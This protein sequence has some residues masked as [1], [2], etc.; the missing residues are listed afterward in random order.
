MTKLALQIALCAAMPL[1]EADAPEWVHLLPA[2]GGTIATHDGR[3][4]Y[5]VADPAGIIAA[6]LHADSRDE[7]GLII[8]ENH[9]S[10]LAAPLGLSSPARGHIVDME[11]RADGIWGRVKWN[12]TGA[13]LLSERAYRGISPVIEYRADGTVLRIARASLVNYPNLRGLVALNS[14]SVMDLKQLATSLGLNEAATMEEIIAA[15][16]KLKGAGTAETALQSEIGGIVGVNGDRAALLAA[17]RL[18]VTGREELVALNASQAAELKTLKE[19]S[20]K[21]VS[22]AY[23]DGQIAQK[24]MGLNAAN[25]AEFV[26]LHMSQ[27]DACQKIVEGMPLGVETHT[28]Q[29]PKVQP[30]DDLTALSAEA[31]GRVLHDRAIALQTEQAAKGLTLSLFDAINKVKKEV[32][33]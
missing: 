9:S 2:L 27:P 13:A 4:P 17:V 15:V 29:V 12:Q 3:G 24:R 7:G 20:Q 30:G 6:S 1:P 16:E 18:A 21:A 11:V 14:E 23:I 26:A 19:A 10:D 28:A 25:R 32:G 5:R 33:L 22:E 31:Q 8:D